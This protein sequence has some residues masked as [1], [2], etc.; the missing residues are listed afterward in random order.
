[1]PSE[2]KVGW[3]HNVAIKDPLH[4]GNAKLNHVAYIYMRAGI[5]RLLFKMTGHHFAFTVIQPPI[6]ATKCHGERRCLICSIQASAAE[7]LSV[8]FPFR[9]H[10]NVHSCSSQFHVVVQHSQLLS[11]TADFR[12]SCVVMELIVN[13]RSCTL[14]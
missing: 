3:V 8:F 10:K 11:L 1:M 12:R 9:K 4:A 14:P 5:F 2:V 13:T 6:M 7:D